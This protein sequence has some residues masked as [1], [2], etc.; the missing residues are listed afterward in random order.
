MKVVMTIEDTAV[1]VRVDINVA[2]NGWQDGGERST[3]VG[4]AVSCGLQLDLLQRFGGLRIE[5]FNSGARALLSTP[6]R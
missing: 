3:A 5:E 6:R 1:G 4:A 2:F